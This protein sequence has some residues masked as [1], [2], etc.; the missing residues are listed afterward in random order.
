MG[1]VHHLHG[2]GDPRRQLATIRKFLPDFGVSSH[3]GFGRTAD[4]LGPLTDDV[5][6]PSN[7]IDIMISD[8]K[9]QVAL[10][11]QALSR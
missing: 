1:T 5:T 8:H 7:P 3:A 10:L 4:R 9:E 2:P 6:K 11:N